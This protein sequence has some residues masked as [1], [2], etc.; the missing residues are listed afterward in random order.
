MLS[1][2]FITDPDTGCT[3]GARAPHFAVVDDG[4]VEARPTYDLHC[5]QHGLD[6]M[7]ARA[8]PQLDIDE[9]VPRQT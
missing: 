1:G 3:C 9:E 7:L 5:P 2:R 8:D 4:L 6:A